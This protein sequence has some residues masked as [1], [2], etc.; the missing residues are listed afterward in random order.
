[1]IKPKVCHRGSQ[2]DIEALISE[3]EARPTI[4]NV[5]LAEYKD[6]KKNLAQL[7]AMFFSAWRQ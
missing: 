5:L 2:F 7:F 1:L 3:I 4:W 6:R